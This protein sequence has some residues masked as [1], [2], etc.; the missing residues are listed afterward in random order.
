MYL[1]SACLLGIDCKYSGG[2]NSC[3]AVKN[4]AEGHSYIAVCPEVA[5]GLAVPRPPC[6]ILGGRV[7][8]KEG[9][10]VTQSFIDGATDVITESKRRALIA[11]EEIEL[12]ILKSRSPSCG[13]GKIYDGTFSGR[14]IDGDG[15]F[16]KMVKEL[17]IKVISEE[18]C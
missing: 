4:L 8:N 16:A 5:G 14:L 6:E 1:I 3:Q 9:E 12:A 13:S 17:G 11:E 2:N 18:D 10:D 15:I 7:W